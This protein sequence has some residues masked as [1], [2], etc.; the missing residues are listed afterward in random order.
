MI[1]HI[2]HPD[3]HTMFCG[4]NFTSGYGGST[5]IFYIPERFENGTANGTPCKSC[6]KSYTEYKLKKDLENPKT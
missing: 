6:L 3:K 4:K 1:F 2:Y 5:F